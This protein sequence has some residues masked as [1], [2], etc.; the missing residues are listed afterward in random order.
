MK[1]NNNLQRVQIILV[2]TQDGANIGSVCR[3]M[4]TMGL[5]HLVLVTDRIY[6][7]NRVSTLALHAKDLWQNRTEY[8][9]LEEALKDSIIS[10]AATRRHGKNRKASFVSPDQLAD[11]ISK[12]GEGKISIV[13][14]RESDGLTDA[15]VNICNEVVT[16]PTSDNFPSL[17][18]SQ[19]VQI[20][21]YTLFTK[22]REFPFDVQPVNDQRAESATINI[23][24]SLESL[25]FFKNDTEK[26]HTSMFLKDTF[27]RSRY[28]E[29]EMKRMERIFEKACKIKKY[30]FD[31]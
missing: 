13:F 3:A 21:T 29:T 23:M 12:T 20:I 11:I 24:Q 9:T 10:F 18:L 6:D 31:N 8:S 26:E 7:E 4:K 15:E 14:G 2:D 28:S 27:L 22:I 30:K 19:A 25:E 5:S 1:S 17:N 16:I